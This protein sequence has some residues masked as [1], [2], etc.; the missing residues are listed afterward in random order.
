M[1]KKIIIRITL[2]WGIIADII[3]AIRMALP[4]IF[5]STTGINATINISFRYALLYGVPVM[6]GW[7]ILL[8]WTDR[9]PIE[10]R[11][12]FIC[13]IP[14]IIGYIIIEIIGIKI[15]LLNIQNTITTFILQTIF[16]ILTIISFIKAVRITQR[17]SFNSY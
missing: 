9:K 8:F 2:W 1:N 14:V 16:L 17:S 5:I 15:G 7:S 4:Q 13:L 11:G 10:R 6:L 3:E 12:I